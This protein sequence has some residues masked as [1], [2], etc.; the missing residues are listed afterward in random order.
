MLLDDELFSNLGGH[1]L[2]GNPRNIFHALTM[3]PNLGPWSHM[4]EDFKLDTWHW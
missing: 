3:S 4:A 2:L 1:H